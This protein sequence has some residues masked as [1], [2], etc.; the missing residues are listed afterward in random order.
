TVL[1]AV[2]ILILSASSTLTM[3][4]DPGADAARAA[5][6][7]ALQASMQAAQAAQQQMQLQMQQTQADTQRANDQFRAQMD[8]NLEEMKARMAG[9][10]G[11][12][13]FAARPVFSVKPGIYTSPQQVRIYDNTRDAVI[14]YTTDGWTPTAASK[15][16]TG[17]ITIDS[18][19]TLRAIAVIPGTYLRRSLVASAQ[20][21]VQGTAGAP[22]AKGAAPTAVA[23]EVLSAPV[24]EEQ[25]PVAMPPAQEADS[26]NPPSEYLLQQ[27]LRVHLVFAAPVNSK[28]AEVGERI[29]LTVDQEI[30]SGD[31]VVVPRGTLAFATIAH[32]NHTGPG[33][34]PGDI[35]FEV[36]SMT[37]NGTTVELWG[38][39]VMEGQPKP[40]NASF[41]IPV[42]GAFT[43]FRH[44]KDAE[45]RAGM[46]VN[47]YVYADTVVPALKR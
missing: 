9:T 34:A 12:C 14:Y 5:Q 43:I 19:T 16:Y 30:L 44:G 45:I 40:P 31:Q 35:A 29:P 18:T 27:G 23:P 2:A 10:R 6:Q 7:A 4:Q 3:A 36:Q 37:V 25:N 33:G 42:V 32:V 39:A 13:A 21:T 22:P 15:L 38:E 20:Y 26:T 24:A 8:Q 1:L 17:P 11:C 46:P 41:L 47:A 28:T